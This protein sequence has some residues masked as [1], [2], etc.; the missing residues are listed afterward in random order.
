[1]INASHKSKGIIVDTVYKNTQ[2]DALFPTFS[3]F[4]MRKVQMAETA[5]TRTLPR[6]KHLQNLSKWIVAFMVVGFIIEFA[7]M[8]L[9]ND[10]IVGG[11]LHE[12]LTLVEQIARAA[13][14]LASAYAWIGIGSFLYVAFVKSTA[15]L[16]FRI[17]AFIVAIGIGLGLYYLAGSTAYQTY[18]TSFDRLWGGSAIT[19]TPPVT[20]DDVAAVAPAV[21]DPAQSSTPFWLRLMASSALFIGIGCFLTFLK[22]AHHVI[23]DKLANIR[24]VLAE[25]NMILGKYNRAQ[26]AKSEAIAKDQEINMQSDP[27]YQQNHV[28]GALISGIQGWQKQIEARRSD[29]TNI[30]TLSPEEYKRRNEIDV[31]IDKAIEETKVF[32]TDPDKIR[33]IVAGVFSKPM[34]PIPATPN[35][36][37]A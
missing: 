17:T 29:T 23:S 5:K 22:L 14:A 25:A 37:T 10:K 3:D 33:Q 32:S 31:K 4:V 30:G 34:P 15:N 26:S 35:P 12:E 8:F 7:V 20:I 18:A 11:N 6:E 21:I 16:P 9:F 24:A 2:I 19:S 1:V 28:L 36:V 27:E 13:V